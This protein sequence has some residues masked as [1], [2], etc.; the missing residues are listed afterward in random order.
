[1][2]DRILELENII[3]ENDIKNNS[4]N[5]DKRLYNT[6]NFETSNIQQDEIIHVSKRTVLLDMINKIEY[7]LLNQEMNIQLYQ[8]MYQNANSNDERNKYLRIIDN[9]TSDLKESRIKKDIL[10]KMFKD[11]K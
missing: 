4:L 1:M 9:T 5:N 6:Y 7:K 3:K 11:M 2:K 8:Y 10:N